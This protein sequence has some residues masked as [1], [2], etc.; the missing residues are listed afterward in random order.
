MLTVN[1]QFFGGRGS[2]G[3][4]HSGGGGGLPKEIGVEDSQAWSEDPD[5]YQRLADP[6]RREAALEDLEDSGYTF[7]EAKEEFLS[8]ANDIRNRAESQTVKESTL[9]R[10][11]RFNSLSAAQAKYRVG[12]E[13]STTQL[14]SYSTDKGLAKS[15]ASMYNGKT[16]VVIT[17]T[18]TTGKFV[19]VRTRHYGESAGKGQEIIVPKGLTSTVKSTRYDK[20]TNTLYVT[21]ENSAKPKRRGR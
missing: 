20:K 17:N 2:G 19:G 10:G 7:E 16:S 14:T 3:G 9:Y 11:E 5:L 4:K 12:A 15:Y 18:A 21:M 6:A 13:V 8:V 1:I